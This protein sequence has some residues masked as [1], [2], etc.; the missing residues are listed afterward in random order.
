[1][2]YCLVCDHWVTDRGPWCDLYSR[3]EWIFIRDEDFPSNSNLGQWLRVYCALSG[4]RPP[5]LEVVDKD[6]AQANNDTR[7]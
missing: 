2:K 1:M 5:G 7:P 6:H 3:K 4:R